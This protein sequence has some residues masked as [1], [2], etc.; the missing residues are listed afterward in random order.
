MIIQLLS[1]TGMVYASWLPITITSILNMI[2]SNAVLDELQERWMLIGLIYIDVL[3]SPL[4]LIMAIPELQHELMLWINR[5]KQRAQRRRNRILP[6]TTA[7]AQ[8]H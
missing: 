1:I 7:G 8:T 6:A 2:Y 3:F 5:W 4:G